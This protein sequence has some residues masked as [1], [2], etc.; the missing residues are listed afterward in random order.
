MGMYN[1]VYKNC[2]KCGKSCTQQI[3]QIVLG[4]G[5]FN[6][7]SPDSLGNELTAEQL[8]ELKAAVMKERFWCQKDEGGCGNN[9]MLGNQ[10]QQRKELA[11]NLF[12]NMESFCP[13]CN[14]P[15]CGHDHSNEGKNK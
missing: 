11:R 8:Y 15:A 1:E 2:P 3:A 5:Q 13:C 6:L 10:D 9:F 7:D 14:Y 4:F 12:D